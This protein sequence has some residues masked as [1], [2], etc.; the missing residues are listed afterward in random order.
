MGGVS[1]TILNIMALVIRSGMC[2]MGGVVWAIREP[3]WHEIRSRGV[4]YKSDSITIHT[5]H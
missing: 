5:V 1:D 2:D 3:E 4:K